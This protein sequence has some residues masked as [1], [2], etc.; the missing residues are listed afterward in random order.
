[1]IRNIAYTIFRRC[2]CYT[3]LYVPARWPGCSVKVGAAYCSVLMPLLSAELVFASGLGPFVVSMCL[4]L[5]VF[6]WA[7]SAFQCQFIGS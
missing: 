7:M 4:S 1:M 5:C 6:G 2:H 3:S